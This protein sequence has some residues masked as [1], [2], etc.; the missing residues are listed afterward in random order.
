M[1]FEGL[2]ASPRIWNEGG[3]DPYIRGMLLMEGKPAGQVLETGF[4]DSI[5]ERLFELNRVSNTDLLSLDIQR[6]RDHGLRTYWDY[7]G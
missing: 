7:R 1:L 6:G 2:H 4:S 5:R 3:V